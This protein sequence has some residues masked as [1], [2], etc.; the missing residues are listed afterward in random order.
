MTDRPTPREPTRPDSI[1]P[2]YR[3]FSI[4][5]PPMLRPLRLAL[6]AGVVRGLLWLAGRLTVPGLQRAGR[7]LGALVY[8]LSPRQRRLCMM[9][10]AT[11]LPEIKSEFTKVRTGPKTSEGYGP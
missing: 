5:Y 10:L 8:A 9:Q 4:H 6:V 2:D 7:V 1:R 3:G 11:A